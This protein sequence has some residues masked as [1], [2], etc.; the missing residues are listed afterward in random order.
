[1]DVHTYGPADR[2]TDSLSYR[3]TVPTD[4]SKN[5]VSPKLLK[6]EESPAS[7]DDKQKSACLLRA[8]KDK[9]YRR[10]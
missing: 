2:P 1:M 4:A 10:L 3:D 5:V 6:S 7:V 9:C 8:S